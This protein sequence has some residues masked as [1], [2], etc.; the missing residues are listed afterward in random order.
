[1]SLCP[2]EKILGWVSLS[3]STQVNGS[4]SGL[5]PI[6]H[7]SFE[8]CGNPLSSCC[9]IL[10]T[11]QPA[12]GIDNLLTDVKK[13]KKKEKK[14][15]DSY[16]PCHPRKLV[17]YTE[18]FPLLWWLCKAF[19]ICFIWRL[20]LERCC[21]CCATPHVKKAHL[22]MNVFNHMCIHLWDSQSPV[23]CWVKKCGN[24]WNLNVS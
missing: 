24:I 8:F 18:G 5:R 14:M 15:S 4:H 7:P 23:T 2:W 3:R 1:M 20:K 17:A 6:L 13:K 16:Q 19:G 9:A 12:G 10:L 21:A 22:H 11:N